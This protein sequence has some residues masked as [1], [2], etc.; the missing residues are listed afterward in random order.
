MARITVE[1]M[2]KRYTKYNDTPLLVTRALRRG[3][4]AGREDLWA[5]R[6][7]DLSVEPG[8][9]LGVIGRN[10]SGKSTLLRLLA[11]V[12]APT[13]GRVAVAGRIAPLLAVGVGFHPELTGRENTYVNGIILG[14]TRREIDERF[15]EIVE[16]AEI[17]DF[18]DTPVKFYSS[19]MF[20]RLGFSVS[21]LA[22]PDVLL[23][24]EVLAVGDLAFGLKCLDRMQEVRDAGTTLVL[25][26][27]N[28]HSIRLMCERTVVL[29]G[30]EVR[31]DGD[32]TDAIALFHDLLG[33][34]REIDGPGAGHHAPFQSVD[35]AGVVE[36]FA[37][38]GSDGQ[39]TGH[40]RAGERVT[41]ALEVRF[42][43]AVEKAILGVNVHS[44]SGVELLADSSPWREARRFEAGERVRCAVELDTHLTTGTYQVQL[45]LFT[46]NGTFVTKVPRP[47]LFFVQGREQV[48][49]LVDLGARFDITPDP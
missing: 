17:G 49:G 38:L 45:T 2:S 35:E 47:I 6:D 26:S 11:G 9:C 25:V 14:L 7:V 37:L 40:V 33:E 43:R 4:H 44:Q 34:D 3:V 20:V 30:G 8:E 12:T 31:H 42:D 32:T 5:L 1:A 46:A 16:F 13:K 15:D 21:I 41:A 22:D 23:I 28:L 19:G 39:P 29:H 27:H 18:I 24:D 10:G 36:S 48:G